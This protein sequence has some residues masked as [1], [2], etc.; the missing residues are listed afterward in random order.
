M[1]QKFKVLEKVEQP[2]ASPQADAGRGSIPASCSDDPRWTSA[3]K[4]LPPDPEPVLATDLGTHYVASWDGKDWIDVQSD[5]V[6]D[7]YITHWMWLPDFP[8]E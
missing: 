4:W 2:I 8:E 7:C 3:D 6:I 1:P 5:E